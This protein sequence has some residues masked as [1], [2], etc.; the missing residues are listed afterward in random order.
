MVDDCIK[1][2][3]LGTCTYCYS[4]IGKGLGRHWEVGK[5]K[6]DIDFGVRGLY[7]RRFGWM[8]NDC[9]HH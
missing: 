6:Q 7:E 3:T 4:S 2:D 1:I 5:R 9:I 8:I